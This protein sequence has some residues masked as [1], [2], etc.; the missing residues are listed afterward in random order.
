MQV[1][2][3]RDTLHDY[4][5][6]C[7]SNNPTWTP[8]RVSK[9]IYHVQPVDAKPVVHG[10]WVIDKEHFRANCSVC[11]ITLNYTDEMQIPLLMSNENYC[12]NCGADMRGVKDD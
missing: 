8:Q 6:D 4:F 11:G 12:Y 7:N 3:D 9:M 5:L 10:E 2:I 1:L